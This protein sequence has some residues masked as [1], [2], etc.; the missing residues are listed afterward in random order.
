MEER[1][2]D[3]V[4]YGYASGG[5]GA[6]K[7]AHLTAPRVGADDVQNRKAAKSME[8]FEEW[9]RVNSASLYAEFTPLGSGQRSDIDA[10]G[11]HELNIDK[12]SLHRDNTKSNSPSVTKQVRVSGSRSTSP[13]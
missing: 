8:M 7:Q 2:T 13:R 9:F 12:R 4:Q 1:L 5:I 11:T 6:A 10:R 3:C